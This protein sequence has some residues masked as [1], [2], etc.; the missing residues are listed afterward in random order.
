MLGRWKYSL[1]PLPSPASPASLKIDSSNLS[2]PL[3]ILSAGHYLL[4]EWIWQSSKGPPGVS[5]W[6]PPIILNANRVIFQNGE[7]S[8][9]GLS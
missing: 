4:L 6:P 2:S 7:W 3:T 1:N 8:Q 9:K 5:P